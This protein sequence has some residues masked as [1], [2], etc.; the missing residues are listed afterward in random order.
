MS[1]T[2]NMH[3]AKSQ[4]SRLVERAEAGEEIIIARAGKP[5]ARLMPLAP[6]GKPRV[7]GGWRGKVKMPDDIHAGDDEIIEM[8]EESINTPFPE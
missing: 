6:A 1:A 7:F 8:F 3:E 4:L 2:V 5:A